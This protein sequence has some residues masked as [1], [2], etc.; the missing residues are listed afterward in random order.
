MT[1]K[2]NRELNDALVARLL[3]LKK[4]FGVKDLKEHNWIRNTVRHLKK[5][6][7]KIPPLLDEYIMLGKQIQN[8]NRDYAE[9]MKNSCASVLI[10]S[11]KSKYWNIEN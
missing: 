11:K 9:L 2:Q 8:V 10:R 1:V 5:D 6:K 3:Q 7:K 4:M